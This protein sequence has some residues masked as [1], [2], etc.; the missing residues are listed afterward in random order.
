MKN[1]EFLGLPNVGKSFFFKKIKKYFKKTH[2]YQ[3]IFYFWLFKNKKINYLS[4][5]LIV[6]FIFNEI[7][8]YKKNKYLFF[9]Q[10]KIY[11]F[12]KTKSSSELEIQHNKVKKKY[13]LFFKK[14]SNFL[15]FHKE[16]DRL[17]KLFADILLGYELAKTMKID[18]ISSEG[19]VQ[20][21]FSVSLRKKILK[22]DLRALSSYLPNPS[23]I[24]YLVKDKQT[25]ISIDEIVKVYHSKNVKFIM[26]KDNDKKFHEIFYKIST[27][28]K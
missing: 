25:N 23:H 27:I 24:I 17:S 2:N 28:L 18:L 10:R 20:R 12:L 21:L 6:H 8:D 13:R 22:R 1:I 14:L 26:L 7:T 16:T 15:K 9:F 4:Y 3:S 19:L 5:K 11:F